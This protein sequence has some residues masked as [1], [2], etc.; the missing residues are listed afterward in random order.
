MIII[1]IMIIT[2]IMITRSTKTKT[3]R[4]LSQLP[5]EITKNKEITKD[6]FHQNIP[7]A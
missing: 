5:T 4:A 7:E 6:F 2:T 3:A 1:I